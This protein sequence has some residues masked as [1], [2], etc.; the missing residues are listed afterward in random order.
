MPTTFKIKSVIKSGQ[1]RVRL[2]VGDGAA[3]F[4][5]AQTAKKV[6]AALYAAA[7]VA[8]PDDGFEGLKEITI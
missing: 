1:P 7:Q 4:L 2:T 3:V 6:A 8:D 5:D